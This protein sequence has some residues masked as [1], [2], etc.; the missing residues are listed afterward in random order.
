MDYD[1]L[2]KKSSQIGNDMTALA[3]RGLGQLGLSNSDRYYILSHS[4]FTCSGNI[5]GFILGVDVIVDRNEYP[6]VFIAEKIE[7][8]ETYIFKDSQSIQLNAID[9]QTNGVYK[10]ILPSPLPFQAGQFIGIKQTQRNICKV[11]FNYQRNPQYNISKVNKNNTETN[12]YSVAED[13]HL[14]GRVLLHP[15]SSQF[16]IQVKHTCSV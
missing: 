12:Q 2:I 7:N 13:G 10:Y 9:F 11:R 5:T 3:N 6:E 4:T 14:P 8:E 1:L 15:I 16:K